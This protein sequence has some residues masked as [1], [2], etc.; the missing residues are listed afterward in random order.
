[1]A[2]ILVS[3]SE[4]YSGKSS[5][6][7]G[8]GKIFQNK[9]YV[10]GYMKPVG[11]LL[12]NVY[13]S[14]V[15]EDSESIKQ[16]LGLQDPSELIT[17][18]YLTDS[19]INDTL[20]GI[21]KDLDNKLREAYARIS[22]GKDIVI[23]EGT[24]GIG[25]GAMYDLS[26]PEIASKL[27][28][29]MLLVTRFDSIYAV[30]RILC[31][32]RIIRDPDM[33]AGVILN[34]VPPAMLDRVKELVVPFLERRGISVFGVIPQDETLRSIP[35]SDIV[36]G[37]HGDV[38]V[39]S[40]RLAEL[41]DNYLVGAMEAGSAIKYFRRTPDSAVI[42]GGDRADIQMAAIEARV[43]CI[44]LTGNMQPSGA[45]LSSAEAA[46][47]PVVLVRGDT[48]STIERMEHLIG[49]A[50]VKQQVKLDRI[51]S[52]LEKNV[53]VEAIAESMGIKI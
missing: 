51:L 8:L 28:T 47:I 30:D 46:G 22:E 42:T 23:I 14:L 32:L 39:G 26:D 40:D 21:R 5:I 6:C 45:V 13:G 52:L 38:L 17:P 18:V 50:H 24:G 31:D 29:R 27:G 7:M 11:N 35:V 49:H 25:G 43:K 15:D 37:L 20:T 36:D 34:E 16:L 3:S 19:L 33:L 10:I 9:G 48:M 53:N 44:V 2:S 12:I 4:E 1:M 41:V